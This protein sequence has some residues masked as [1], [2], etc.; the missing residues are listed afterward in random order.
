MKR[1]T[2][3]NLV[4]CAMLLALGYVL[5]TFT[6]SIRAI[7]KMLTPMH[8][9][10]LICGFLCGAPY[11][12][13][14]GFLLP[15]LRSFFAGM[16]PLFP[17]ACAMAVELCTYGA[18]SGI[19]YRALHGKDRKGK[20]KLFALYLS[21]VSAML[22]GRFA[23]GLVTWLLLGTAGKAWSL[24]AFFTGAFA[25]AVPGIIL[26]LILIPTV[27]LACSSGEPPRAPR[28]HTLD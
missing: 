4:I 3:T 7:G 2:Y 13:F 22:L 9:P 8:F 6:G 14:I 26:Q 21:L 20:S 1:R 18:V 23:W 11:G 10:V 24:A 5:P 15:F 17:N 19:L 28:D 25:A 16:P 12:A 27:V